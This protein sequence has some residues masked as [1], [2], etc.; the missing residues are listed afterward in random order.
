[1]DEP[2]KDKPEVET[3]SD[4]QNGRQNQIENSEVSDEP[5]ASD[6]SSPTQ[7]PPLPESSASEPEAPL[8]SDT[9]PTP[10]VAPVAS[11]PLEVS[12]SSP[13]AGVIILQWLT[14][15]FWGWTILS[16]VWLIFIVFASIF[17]SMDTSDM[18]PY[19]IAAVLVLLPI[20][21][22][23]DIFYGKHEPQKKT[24]ASMVVMVIHAVIFALFGI[25]MLITG[26]LTIVQLAIGS[27]SNTDFQNVWI[28][29]AFVSA[30]VYALTFLRTLNPLPKLRLPKIFPIAMAV[31]VGVFI[32]A[33]FIGPVAQASLTKND[34]VIDATIDDVSR[35]VETYTDK[36]SKLP[37]SLADIDI[38]GDTKDAVDQGLYVYKPENSGLTAT[39]FKLDKNSADDISS[40]STDSAENEYRYQLCVTYKKADRDG[41]YSSYSSS[42]EYSSYPYTSGHPAGEVCYKLKTSSYNS[43]N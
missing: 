1:M 29:T 40:K 41:G 5:R 17:T 34:R 16:L 26:V 32:V 24:G 30:A 2:I 11:V 28:I 7:I 23:C 39:V 38:S 21:F 42:R 35:A 18:V 6:V 22:I 36:N 9:A 27:S 14:Y 43:Y 33:G 8:V 13:S 4:T 20:S 15:A 25:G 10:A 31:I 37:A 12:K 19:A 3:S